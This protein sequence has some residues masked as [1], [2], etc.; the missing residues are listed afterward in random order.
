[1]ISS[2]CKPRVLY[3]IPELHSVTC[4]LTRKH[5]HPVTQYATSYGHSADE[6]LHH[7]LLQLQARTNSQTLNAVLPLHALVIT[8]GSYARQPIFFNNNIMSLYLS[9]G[10]LS[11]ARKLFDR[12]SERNVVSYNTMITAY[13]HQWEVE[14]AW[15][16]FYGMRDCGFVPTQATFSSLLSCAALDT[17]RGCMLHA[18]MLKNGLFHSDAYAGTALLVMFGRHEC[19]KEAVCV[20]KE[21]P[22]KSLITWNSMISLLGS[23]GFVEESMFLFQE[24][25]RSIYGFSGSTLVS[26]LSGLMCEKDLGLG[27]QLHGLAV[28]GGLDYEVSV[29]NTLLNMYVKCAGDELVAKMFRDMPLQDVVSYNTLIGAFAKALGHHGYAVEAL[30]RFRA[31]ELQGIKPDGVTFVAVL[32]ACRHGGLVEEGMELF[33]GIENA[34]KVKPEMDHYRG[35]VD[36]LA[37]SGRLKEA[38][39]LIASMPFPPDALIWRSFFGGCRRQGIV[40]AF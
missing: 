26:L 30:E 29:S 38:E 16:M 17:C 23:H 15:D 4:L 1:M 6:H 40:N 10:E 27:E 7:L 32:S 36:L 8:I 25:M 34:S 31:M 28:K 9:F 20:F 14:L 21:L 2:A 33:S 35:A 12:M 19:L 37:R 13:S 39:Q 11:K 22:R 3:T 18:L 5:Y 24:L